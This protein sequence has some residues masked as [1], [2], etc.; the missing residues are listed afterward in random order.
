M[1]TDAATLHLNYKQDR[2]FIK[3][4][5]REKKGKHTSTFISTTWEQNLLTHKYF[6]RY[7]WLRFRHQF[8]MQSYTHNEKNCRRGKNPFVL[9][10]TIN[11]SLSVKLLQ[12]WTTDAASS[13]PLSRGSCTE[14]IWANCDLMPSKW[15]LTDRLSGSQLKYL[16]YWNMTIWLCC[17]F[18]HSSS[19]PEETK[20]EDLRIHM[21]T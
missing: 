4:A 18:V 15:S 17:I 10:L 3:C 13:L 19:L 8:R 2:N 11:T 5:T 14:C 12:T 1:N 6:T 9:A 20:A 21:E 16:I 7:Y